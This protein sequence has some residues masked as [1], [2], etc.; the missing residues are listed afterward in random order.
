MPVIVVG[1]LTVGG[2]G[3]TP[4][5]IW[6]VERLRERG[7]H[8][9]IVTRGYGGR[10]SG[11][12][13]HVGPD[14]V[15]ETAGDEAVLL[16]RRLGCPVVACVDRVAGVRALI[17]TGSVDVVVSDDG[18]QHFALHRDCEIVVVDGRRGLG[19]GRLLP[20]GPLR[21]PAGRLDDAD[22]VLIHGFAQTREA[23]F[24]ADCR[25]R[26]EQRSRD[27]SVASRGWTYS[28]GIGFDLRCTTVVQLCDGT[29]SSLASFRGRQVHAHAAIGHPRRFF[30]MLRAAGCHVDENPWPDHSA[31][32]IERL[33]GDAPVLIT[34]K[35]AVKLDAPV[36]A[37]IWSVNVEL[38]M[39]EPAAAQVLNIVADRIRRDATSE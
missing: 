34:Q 24:E 36:P 15:A 21:E 20:A 25:P 38:E 13:L 11:V 29:E 31:I 16:A 7:L 1:N 39:P 9:G 30:A 37:G 18:L 14:S 3:K 2:T 6:L 28:G 10:G 35:D 8:P 19:N 4:V 5:V 22:V 32:P 17:D 27:G 12:P 23:A 26:C 33:V